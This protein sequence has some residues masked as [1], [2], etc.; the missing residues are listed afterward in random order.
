VG[1]GGGGAWGADS[2]TACHARWNPFCVVKQRLGV[3]SA[4]LMN[5]LGLETAANISEQSGHARAR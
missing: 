5:R 4:A 3:R 1:E 2:G